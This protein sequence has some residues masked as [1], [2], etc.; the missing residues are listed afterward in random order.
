MR[1]EKVNIKKRFFFF[2]LGLI[3]SNIHNHSLFAI[4]CC[5]LLNLSYFHIT[6]F[7]LSLKFILLFK[8]KSMFLSV[9]VMLHSHHL[10]RRQSCP[11]L[12]CELL[13]FRVSEDA[14]SDTVHSLFSC[15]KGV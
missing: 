8:F 6:L 2:S 15:S 1:T 5:S 11:D 14:L 3:Q 9:N 10:N 12:F 13:S 4:F 7:I